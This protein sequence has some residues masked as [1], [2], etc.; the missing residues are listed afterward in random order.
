MEEGKF[1][2]LTKR[3]GGEM[4]SVQLRYSGRDVCK[5]TAY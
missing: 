2:L 3:G 5:D 4:P 1:G